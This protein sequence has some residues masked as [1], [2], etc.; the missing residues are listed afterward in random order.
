MIEM[1]NHSAFFALVLSLAAYFLGI[2]VKKRWNHPLCN[3]LLLSIVMVI[4]VL[5]LLGIPYETYAQSGSYLSYLL[6]PATVALAIPL[7]Q[8][9]QQ[10][11]A[12][13]R[14]VMLGIFSGVLCNLALIYVMARYFVLDYAMYVTLL[15]KSITTAIGLS[16]SEEYGGFVSITATAI[17]I[18]GIL[19]NICA[20]SLCKLCKI[21]HPVAK[22]VAIGTSAHAVGTS[23]AMEIGEVEGAMS[24]LSI[25]LTGLCTLLGI[26]IFAGL[27]PV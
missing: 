18:T 9:F 21:G 14:P 4:G 15:P 22:G 2:E 20:E 5:L 12:H 1:L 24:S 10:F 7:Y 27:Y 8:Q 13:W 16:I 6:T 23:K 19:G 26:S 25:V 3:P 11:R 17:I